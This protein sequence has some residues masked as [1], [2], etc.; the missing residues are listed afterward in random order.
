MTYDEFYTRYVGEI[1]HEKPEYIRKGQS[2]M[3]F[4]SDVWP[5]EYRR[6]TK[7]NQSIDC[8][9]EDT[10]VSKTLFHLEKIWHKK[11]EESNK[12]TVYRT[13]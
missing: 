8:F 1:L 9:Y 10:I 2:L 7:T 4:L 3:N 13:S 6:I 11:D 12:H 5:E